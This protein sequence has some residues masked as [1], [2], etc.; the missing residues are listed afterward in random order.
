MS[1][2]ALWLLRLRRQ[3]TPAA[4]ATTAR[5]TAAKKAGTKLRGNVATGPMLA[6]L[7]R[8][9]PLLVG[10]QVPATD[11]WQTP[12]GS[13]EKGLL[14]THFKSD[15]QPPGIPNEVRRLVLVHLSEAQHVPGLLVHSV[16]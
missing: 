11:I 16:L 9:V 14:P 2:P 5:A 13:G 1:R 10:G 15:G 6:S 4:A 7:R 8:R 3:A 12:L